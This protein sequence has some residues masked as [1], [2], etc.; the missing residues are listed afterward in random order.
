MVQISFSWA[1][2]ADPEVGIPTYETLGSSGADIRANLDP[3][4][5]LGGIILEPG[6]VKLIPTGFKLAIPDGYEIQ[7]RPRSGLAIKHKITVLNSPGTIDSDYRGQIGII[8]TNFGH[9]EF[10]VEHGTRIAQIVVAPVIKAKFKHVSFIGETLR[11]G[12]G[13]GSTGI[14]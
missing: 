5:R 6:D 3:K 7:I 14:D 13:F 1:T 4:E 2:G 8:L 11:G 12:D 9:T 10:R